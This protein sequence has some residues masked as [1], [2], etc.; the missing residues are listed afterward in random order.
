MLA[1]LEKRCG[2]GAK[3]DDGAPYGFDE[4]H[5]QKEKAGGDLGTDYFLL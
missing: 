1:E 5:N 4:W 2:N 3:S